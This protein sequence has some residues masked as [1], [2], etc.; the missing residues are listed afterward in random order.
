MFL[1][2]NVSVHVYPRGKVDNLA[3]PR[4]VGAERDWIVWKDHDSMNTDLSLETKDTYT[5]DIHTQWK[6]EQRKGMSFCCF[7]KMFTIHAQ[8]S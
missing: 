8:L 1:R 4:A 5:D 7:F 6:T 2:T 3:A